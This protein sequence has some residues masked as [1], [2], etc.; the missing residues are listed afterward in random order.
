MCSNVRK[1]NYRIKLWGENL[2]EFVVKG[3]S[4]KHAI[5]LH[6]GY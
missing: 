5:D 4:Q 1:C 3:L 2:C 6:K